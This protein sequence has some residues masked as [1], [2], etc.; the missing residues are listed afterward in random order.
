MQPEERFP[1][2]CP[3]QPFVGIGQREPTMPKR[4]RKTQP[5]KTPAALGP[6]WE[7]TPQP[8]LFAPPPP[9]TGTE[10]PCDFAGPD[11]VKKR[12]RLRR[13]ARALYSRTHLDRPGPHQ[14]A[15][16]AF[17]K[18]FT[19]TRYEREIWAEYRRWTRLTDEERALVEEDARAEKLAPVEYLDREAL[20]ELHIYCRKHGIPLEPGPAD[21][22][23]HHATAATGKP[24]RGQG[25]G[26]RR[27]VHQSIRPLTERQIQAMH[28][29]A[30][31]QENFAKAAKELGICPKSLKECYMAACKK[32]GQKVTRQ[33]KPKTLPLPSDRR[34]QVAVAAPP[35]E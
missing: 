10:C 4:K 13:L 19:Y 8:A 14:K 6:W 16:I 9:G 24:A 3:T 30:A 34:G 5:K 32:L 35:E 12:S 22:A 1:T 18:R 27:Y 20:N 23:V 11:T 26:R 21:A 29:V 7:E 31:C 2:A 15:A 28:V 25:R 33:P 17:L